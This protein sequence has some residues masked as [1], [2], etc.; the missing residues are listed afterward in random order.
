VAQ[1]FEPVLVGP[2]GQ[3]FRGAAADAFGAVAPREPPVVQEEPQ[4]VQVLRPD[5]PPQ[6]EVAAQTACTAIVAH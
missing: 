3:E 4:Q 6:E 5:L 2:A 1:E